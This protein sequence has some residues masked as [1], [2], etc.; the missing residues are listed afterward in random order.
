MFKVHKNKDHYFIQLF[1]NQLKLQPRA[2]LGIDQVYKQPV[3]LS[4]F[5]VSGIIDEISKDR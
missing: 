4:K 1:K 5:N 2:D 3:I